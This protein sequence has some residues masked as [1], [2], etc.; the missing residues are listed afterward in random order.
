MKLIILSIL[1]IV[2]INVID[3]GTPVEWSE[4]TYN[5]IHSFKGTK[6]QFFAALTK[7]VM[8]EMKALKPGTMTKEKCIEG[9]NLTAAKLTK[10]DVISAAEF[11]G[12]FEKMMKT[13][14]LP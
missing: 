5:F 11:K 10:D 12:F 2:L 14:P 8:D 9:V 1:V 6:Q 13:F 7:R 3:A 4:D